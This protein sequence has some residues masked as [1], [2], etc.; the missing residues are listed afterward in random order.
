MAND[1]TTPDLTGTWTLD[2]THS[3]LG[4]SARH[5]MVA[6]VR[7]GFESFSG[8]ITIDADNP[9]ASKAEVT[10]DASSIT[11]GNADRDNHLRTNDFLDVPNHPNLT[12]TS[13]GVKAG[14]DDAYVLLGDLT[15]R[16]VTRPVE[17]AI[18]FQGLAKDPFGNTRAGF[19]GR[20]SIN[21]KDFGVSF[22]APL[23]TGGVLVS[24][25]VKIELDISAIK[26][27]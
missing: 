18:E 9:A 5:A 23:E 16:G 3:R 20:T 25:K 14:Q 19:E 21:R 11:T 12:F 13:T 7:G 8:S 22:N 4:F 2:P 10:I 15:I 27:A 1:V 26:V 6:T 24:D 17:I